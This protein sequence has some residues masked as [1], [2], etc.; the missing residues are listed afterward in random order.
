MI[1]AHQQTCQAT[2]AGRIS[3]PSPIP[4]GR[5]VRRRRTR[6]LSPGQTCRLRGK[7]IAASLRLEASEEVC[8]PLRVSRC[9]EDRPL[10]VFQ[11]LQPALNI[12]CM[13]LARLGGETKVSTQERCA[14]LC[15]QLLAG[16]VASR[17]ADAILV[18]IDLYWKRWLQWGQSLCMF[19]SSI[20]F[21]DRAMRSLISVH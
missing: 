2:G 20:A 19:S 18:W 7:L 6:I 21:E 14:K 13:V 4:Q 8:S 10:V 5:C 12:C 9:R 11:N 15:D 3:F 17:P 16:I 1:F